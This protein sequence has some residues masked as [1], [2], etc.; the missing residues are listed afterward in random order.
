MA[1]RDLRDLAPDVERMARAMLEECAASGVDLLI[2]CT[3]RSASEQ[4]ALYA[5]GRTVP[6]PVL[7]QARPGESMH[8]AMIDGRPAARAFDAVPL[9]AGRPSWGTDG[10]AGRLWERVGAIGEACGLE[11][12]GRWPKFREFPHFQFRG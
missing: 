4:A 1:S 8:N 3:Y 11:W 12:A 5:S 10:Q 7:T 9:V 6:G 2:Y